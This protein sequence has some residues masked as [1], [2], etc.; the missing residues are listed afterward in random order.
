MADR[1]VSYLVWQPHNGLWWVATFFMIGSALFGL[2]CV[3]YLGGVTHEFTINSIFLAGSIFFTKAAFFEFYH[4]P[5]GNRV[6]Y[7][8][9]LSQFIGTLFFNANTFDSFFNFGWFGQE[10]LIWSPNILGSILFLISGSLVMLDVCKCWWCWNFKSL[11]W[12]NGAINFAGCVGFLISAVLS[13]V[14]PSSAS[15]LNETMATM[16]TLFGAVC[17][18]VGAYLMW[19]EMSRNRG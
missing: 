14:L 5:A 6:A 16:F 17:F 9:A 12:W 19:P 4:T 13:F 10:I 8:S 18:F 15:G 2:G 1:P 11:E 3:L 7:W